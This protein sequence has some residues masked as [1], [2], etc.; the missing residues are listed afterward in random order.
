MFE[1]REARLSLKADIEDIF[2][3]GSVLS[4]VYNVY[5]E[6]QLRDTSF[7]PTRPFV[8]L[9]D[10]GIMF[11]SQ[12]LPAIVLET[13]YRK[14]SFELGNPAQGRCMPEI[15][16]FGRNRG[17]RDDLAGAIMNDLTVVHIRDFDTVGHPIQHTSPLVPIVGN[18]VWIAQN[19]SIGQESAFEGSLRN[20]VVL[21][22][23]FWAFAT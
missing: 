15:H 1:I 19:A 11:E 22:C 2:T 6:A 21:S 16:V 4:E 8:Y 9:L 7:V 12:H 10:S 18:D 13:E 3:S 20:W 5:G 14:A 23:A 17:E